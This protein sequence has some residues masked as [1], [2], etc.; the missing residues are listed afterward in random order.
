[1][2]KRRRVDI[3]VTWIYDALAGREPKL[4]RLRGL[5]FKVY[6]FVHPSA[7]KHWKYFIYLTIILQTFVLPAYEPVSTW[8][9]H[10]AVLHDIDYKRAII[11]DVV[12]QFIL[13][14]D[15]SLNVYACGLKYIMDTDISVRCAGVVRIGSMI[16]I[17][18]ACIWRKAF[19]LDRLVRPTEILFNNRHVRNLF[20]DLVMTL[21]AF[22]GVMALYVMIICIW[23]MFGVLMFGRKE[24]GFSYYNDQ[25]FGYCQGNLSNN[26]GSNVSSQIVT[27]KLPYFSE[28]M[29]KMDTIQAVSLNLFVLTSLESWPDVAS[30]TF[31]MDT[32]RRIGAAI[33]WTVYVLV[34]ILFL[35]NIAVPLVYEPFQKRQRKRYVKDKYTERKCIVAAFQ[36]LDV[37]KTQSLDISEVREVFESLGYSSNQMR[38]M[39]QLLDADGDG[40]VDLVEF[41][42]RCNGAQDYSFGL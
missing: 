24:D 36:L 25:L 21:K 12:L 22:G 11:A 5:P 42:G 34:C 23:S 29:Y 31:E 13:L 15:F 10:D 20:I 18:V 38:V 14:I 26:N 8:N 28:Q 19:R 33:Y 1:M 32:I 17:I 6:R 16:N 35:A 30:A 27:V 40:E 7:N 4:R 9:L 39:L 3:A 37:D 41:F 2:N